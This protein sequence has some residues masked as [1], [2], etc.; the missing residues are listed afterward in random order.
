MP[1]ERLEAR[2][3]C[4]AA[5]AALPRP[6]HVVIVVEENHSYGQILGEPALPQRVGLVTPLVSLRATDPYIRALGRHGASF[7]NSQAITHPS[8]PNYLALFSGSTQGVTND[9]T[10]PQPFPGPSLGGELI[11]AGLSF[12]GYSE[13]MPYAGF[14]GSDADGGLYARK[15]NPWVDF[16][17]VPPSSNLPFSAFP[18]RRDFDS[19]PTV[20]F[21]VPNQANDMHSGSIRAADEWLRSHLRSYARWARRHNS[22]L[23]VTW[24]EGGGGDNHIPTIVTGAGVR[25]GRYGQRIDHYNVLRTIEDVY[26]LPHAGASA[27]AAPLAGLFG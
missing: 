3:L 19:L 2:R 20:S 4:A 7:T 18:G 14:T 13:S 27:D 5:P 23:V 11:A 1:V 25:R 26:G 17:D 16:A 22:L 12:A 10:P 24:D 6:D 8:Q 21:V 15:H 9:G